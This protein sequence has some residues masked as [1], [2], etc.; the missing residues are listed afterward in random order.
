MTAT[1]RPDLS[2]HDLEQHTRHA[3]AACRLL[4]QWAAQHEHPLP[5]GLD[6]AVGAARD[7]VEAATGDTP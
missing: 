3:L 5:D 4:I 6:V 1:I 2:Y 7:A